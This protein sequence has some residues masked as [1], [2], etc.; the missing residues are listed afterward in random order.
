[1]VDVNPIPLEDG[2]PHSEAAGGAIGAAVRR[3]E[4]ARLVTGR[5]RFAG[6]VRLDDQAHL[7]VVRSYLPHARVRSIDLSAARAVRGVLAVWTAA[8]LPPSAT[9]VRDDFAP[10]QLEAYAR[11]VLADAEV[12][13]VGE[14]LAVV[15]AEEPY[16]AADA[17]AAIG[18]ELDPLPAAGT[19]KAALVEGGPLVHDG[20]A[21]NVAATGRMGFGDVAAAFSGA[22]TV[23]SERLE[24][25]RIFGAAMEPRAVSAAPDGGGVKLWTSTQSVFTVRDRVASALGLPVADVTVLAED[26]GGGFGPKG[27]PYPEEILVA[28]AAMQLG[29]P[30][31]WT[32]SRT[33]ESSTT[34]H[35]HG[36]VFE[37][38]LAAE[39]D[40]ALRGLR[41][42]MWHD[43]GAYVS[44]GAGIV[45]NIL[46]HLLSAYRVPAMDVEHR[47][48]FTNATP[49]GTVRGGGRPQGNFAMERMMDRLADE[50]GLDRSEVR[51]R[52]LVRPEQMPYPTGLERMGAAVVYDSGD[53][54]RLL[55]EALELIGG[56]SS[57]GD[58]RLRAIGIT[59]G[60][61]STGMGRGEPA[62][63]RIER[64]GTA[65]LYLGS[66]PQGQGH[67][68]MAAQVLADRLGWP[69]DRIKVTT[70]DTRLV[71]RA[72]VTA[73]S[74]SAIHVGN[75]V[76]ITAASAR[77]ELLRR[78]GNLLE[79]DPADLILAAGTVRVVG[80]PTRSVDAATLCDDPVDITES[81]RTPN[82]TMYASSCHAAE[83]AVDP[84]TGGVE[85][86]RYVIVH[87]SGREINR[88]IVEGQLHG[89]LVHGI[90]YALFEE[91]VFTDTAEFLT[92]TFLDYAIPSAPDIAVHPVLVA[93]ETHTTF[94]PES[95]KG[96][97]EAG[98][99]PAPAAV[100]AAV[101]AAIRQRKRDARVTRV[102]IRSSDVYALMTDTSDV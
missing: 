40:G 33:E 16:A 31:R 54:P 92:P 37:L 96:V 65:R 72:F 29:R 101:E 1:M 60:V 42:S 82:G 50:L 73:A 43:I 62:R 30:V 98:T 69:F 7:V 71:P 53:Y 77:E 94:N 51:R 45:G 17:A 87:D 28:F 56:R 89:G 97:G 78:A 20:L 26:V 57:G 85:V 6:D 68:T 35:A 8:D 52:N 27:R 102:P 66:T 70:G 19:L 5:G 91:A 36:T 24:M 63:V 49:T 90:A 18:I 55:D 34:V 74:R 75:A 83:V 81:W 39:P 23:V 47:A 76:A 13:Y 14:G 95:V 15:V 32:A 80:A 9:R 3:V 38:E 21:T 58:G 88:L 59:L 79:A 44:I 12:N 2:Q 61:E 46:V 100:A 41:G 10:P 64:D 25:G 84:D 48:V 22:P 67:Q 4:D 86:T 93:R 11:P 99:I